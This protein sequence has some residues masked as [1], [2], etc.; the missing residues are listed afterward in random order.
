[1]ILINEIFFYYFSLNC[2]FIQ[3]I[4]NFASSRLSSSEIRDMSTPLP[5]HQQKHKPL[6]FTFTSI[7]QPANVT[8][9]NHFEVNIFFQIDIAVQWNLQTWYFDFKATLFVAFCSFFLLVASLLSNSFIFF[10]QQKIEFKPNHFSV[11]YIQCSQQISSS[12]IKKS[13]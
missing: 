11:V 10:R 3:F 12:E 13:C 9:T 5:V 7:P 1:M 4:F 6:K 2:Q 8:S